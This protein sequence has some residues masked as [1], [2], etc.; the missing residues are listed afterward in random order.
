MNRADVVPERSALS[1]AV[2]ALY[3]AFACYPLRPDFAGRI[4]PCCIRRVDSTVWY[5]RPLRDLTVA[6]LGLYPGKAMTTLGDTSEGT[7]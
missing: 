6:D 3:I 4:C 5:A 1:E 2:H 7:N